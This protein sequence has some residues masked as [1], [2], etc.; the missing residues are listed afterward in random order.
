MQLT[1]PLLRRFAFYLCAF[2]FPPL[3][4]GTIIAF[5]HL[6]STLLHRTPP[7]LETSIQAPE[8]PP[9]SGKL[10]AA[11][12]MSNE[13]TQIT[14]LLGAYEILAE[15]GAFDVFTVAPER[16][17]SPT[18][19]AVDVFPHY[20]F[21]NAPPA[22]L[23][24]I[25]AVLDPMNPQLIDWVQ[26]QAPRAQWILSLCEGARL[27]AGAHLFQGKKGTSHFLALEDL[28]QMEPSAQWLGHLR[29]L[30]DGNLISSRGVTA[31][32]DAALFAIEKITS[33]NLAQDTARR[34]SYSWNHA[35][36]QEI[37]IDPLKFFPMFF[38]AGFH[39][40]R[41][42]VG[43]LLTSGTSEMALAAALDSFPRSQDYWLFTTA[44]SRKIYRSAHGLDLVP[45]ESPKENLPAQFLFVP[46]TRVDSA[47]EFLKAPELAHWIQTREIP[48]KS[49]EN[50][51]PGHA[52]EGV[53]SLLSELQGSRITQWIAQMMEYPLP[54]PLLNQKSGSDWPFLLWIK[55][56]LISI[57]SL[58][59]AR[60]AEQKLRKVR[61]N[62]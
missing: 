1:V 61:S 14:D 18:T 11:F 58:G 56:L 53:L 27:A 45:T 2:L 26:K 62:F 20:S 15:S 8:P 41:P 47:S 17:L 59:I 9:L 13:G 44:T 51:V 49:L 60:W 7:P 21:E 33:R 19:G 24:V 3:V 35:E 57:V 29:Y 55:P 48:I 31:S 23:L 50:P 30:Q 25:P 37:Q 43:V 32:L 5:T 36:Q 40:F 38:R 42:P 34:L 54:P 52:Y 28:R 4:I 22:D 6:S 39:W 12:L 16:S 46:D 10:N